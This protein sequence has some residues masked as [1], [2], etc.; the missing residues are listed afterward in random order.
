MDAD[1]VPAAVTFA[2][3]C[4]LPATVP[5]PV[6]APVTAPAS[7]AGINSTAAQYQAGPDAAAS[8]FAVCDPTAP[9]LFGPAIP[10][11]PLV[12]VSDQ[13]RS[14]DDGVPLWL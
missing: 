9:R 1:P 2:G 5:D 12:Y 14:S 3:V 7:G 13:S 6:P 8:R 4:A 10:E 11:V